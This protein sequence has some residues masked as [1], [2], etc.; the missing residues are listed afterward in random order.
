MSHCVIIEYAH[1]IATITINRPAQLNSLSEEGFIELRKVL[2][3]LHD[4]QDLRVVI[5]KGNGK[6]FCAG[7]DIDFFASLVDLPSSERSDQARRYVSLAHEVMALF[8]SLHA[9]VLV[10][11]HG[12]AA[13]FG[14]SLCCIADL[15]VAARGS[16]FVPAY[17]G[18]G[19]TPDG[20]LSYNLPRLIGERRAASVLLTNRSFDAE[21]AAAWG[22][23]T[24]LV[25]ANDLEDQVRQLAKQLAAGARVAVSNT[26]RLLHA[27]RNFN[28]F[29]TTL[30]CE[31][32]SF[33]NCVHADDF[34]EGV[35]AFLDRRTP[36]FSD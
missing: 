27:Q 10:A 9:P 31:L 5:L 19:V 23:V 30:A 11:V 33:A 7:G 24:T 18:L 20:G 32:D 22:L 3:E 15:I 2:H 29:K 34:V 8:A 12:A 25:D 21:Q 35:R 1:H 16:R 14:L 13:G 28:E 36:S 26:L 6:I 4:N 17:L